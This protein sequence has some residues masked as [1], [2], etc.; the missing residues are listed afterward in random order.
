M[1]ILRNMRNGS[2]CTR[3]PF[4][5]T[6]FTAIVRIGSIATRTGYGCP[7]RPWDGRGKATPENRTELEAAQRQARQ[8][9][10]DRIPV[11]G[12]FGQGKRRFGLGR[13]MAKLADT[14][15]TVIALNILVMNLEKLLKAAL[16]SLLFVLW[17]CVVTPAYD[18]VQQFLSLVHR[19]LTIRRHLE[20]FR[21][22]VPIAWH[23]SLTGTGMVNC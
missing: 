2:R 17:L 20:L 22:V 8:D 16:S 15:A 11:E 10:L 19:R 18:A 4:T 9:E 7:A 1:K 23:R 12:K 14:S 3:N 21:G 13:I 5:S 6:R